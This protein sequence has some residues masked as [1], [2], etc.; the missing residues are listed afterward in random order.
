MKLRTVKR[1]FNSHK[2]AQRLALCIVIMAVAFIGVLLL[3]TSHAQ[4]PYVSNTA[5]NGTVSG[6]T[7]TIPNTT[8]STDGKSVVQFGTTPSAFMTRS[9]TNLMLNGKVFQFIGFDT[10]GMTG[11]YNGTA[12]TNAQLDA[13]FSGLPANGM[14][15]LLAFAGYGTATISNILTQAAKYNQHVILSLGNDDGG[16]DGPT[17]GN[18]SPPALSFYQGGWQGSYLTWLNTIVPMFKDNTTIAM[19]E[20]ANE[21][22][23]SV[24]VPEATMQTYLSETAAAIKADDPNHLVTDGVA[25]TSDMG[26]GEANYQA[27]QS[28]PD[29]DVLSMHDYAWDYGD[30]AIEDSDFL[31]AQQAATALNKPFIV[32]EAGVESCVPATGDSSQNG[33]PWLSESQRETYLYTKANDYLSGEYNGSVSGPRAASVMFWDYEPAQSYS[34]AC[35]IGNYEIFPGDPMVSMVQNY[36]M[37]Q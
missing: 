18:V 35:A 32:G 31:A 17:G 22:G 33:L 28:S 20:L 9:G 27:A 16:C 19:W 29:I 30:G 2:H 7:T 26:G 37:P 5:D 36:V 1:L 21:P 11:C 4:S 13:Y 24:T 34:Y 23:Q 8:S 3:T 6:T 12:W 14:T 10:Y 15:R 25:D